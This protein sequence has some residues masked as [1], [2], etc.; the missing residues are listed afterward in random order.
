MAKMTRQTSSAAQLRETLVANFAARLQQVI[1]DGWNGATPL[2]FDDLEAAAV[3]TGDETACAIM[4][5][6]LQEVQD[7]LPPC[8]RQGRCKCG[9]NL[10]WSDKPRTLMTVRGEVTVTRLHGYC[11]V[12]E[13]G[14]FPRRPQ[15]PAAAVA[16]TRTAAPRA[17]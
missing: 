16:S 7:L 9:R 13:R 4:S 10:Q 6:S 3:R 12:C 1:P 17:G 14:F 2:S 15:P 11:R 8:T 5:R